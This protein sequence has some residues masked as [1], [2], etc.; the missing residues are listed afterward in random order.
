LWISLG[1]MHLQCHIHVWKFWWH[2]WLFEVSIIL[3]F[4][5]HVLDGFLTNDYMALFTIGR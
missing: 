1:S 3:I 2:L 5:Q 4:P